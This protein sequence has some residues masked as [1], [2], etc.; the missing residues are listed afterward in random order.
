MRSPITVVGAVIL[1]GDHV[2]VAQ[3]GPGRALAGQWE[4]P[5]G[6]IEPG[7][8]PESALE[9]E[10]REELGACI[11]VGH[12]VE[13]TTH[14]YDFAV[15]HLSTYYAEII[16]GTLTANEHSELRWCRVAELASLDWALA[17]VPA[18]ERVI[19]AF[20]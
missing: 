8:T 14:H 18:V 19:A 2:L 20:T 10:I 6:K 9:R 12:H 17:D 16:S 7:E 15:V 13:T 5:G 11:Q 4:F 3:R 1:K